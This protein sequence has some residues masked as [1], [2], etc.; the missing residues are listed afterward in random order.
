[1]LIAD[2]SSTCEL[3]RILFLFNSVIFRYVCA[4][5]DNGGIPVWINYLDGV[6]L[7]SNNDVWKEEV[8]NWMKVLTDYT[9]DFFADRGGP[10][11]FSQVENELEN[12][13]RE[14]IDWCGEFAQSLE[15]NIPWMMC[16]G[17][18]SELTI[19]ACNGVDCSNF[20]EKGGQSGRIL[21]DQPGCWTENEGWFQVFGDDSLEHDSK[22]ARFSRT[23]PNYA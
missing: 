18:S 7:R 8:A 6:R 4:E 19:N 23:G 1:M 2:F 16:K 17:D 15:L 21:K 14:Y 20:L 9:R 3:D 5:W 12:G 22:V 10:I 11:I 13:S